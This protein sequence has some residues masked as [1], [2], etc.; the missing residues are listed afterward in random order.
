[1]IIDNES[2]WTIIGMII[3]FILGDILKNN[4]KK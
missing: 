2:I 4:M 3:A 1:M